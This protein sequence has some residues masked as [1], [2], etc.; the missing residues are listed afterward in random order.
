MKHFALPQQ[1]RSA[2]VIGINERNFS[3]V[4]RFNTRKSMRVANDKL[5]T[6]ELGEAMGIPCPA[7]LGVVRHCRD[8]K[9]A[10]DM[11]DPVRGA[12]IKPSQ[13]AGSN[14]I[15][16]L[17]S[18]TRN[19]FVKASG[20]FVSD[21]DV[22]WHVS[23]ILSGVFS[24]GGEPDV[25]MVE[26]RIEFDSCF[27]HV[28][29]KGVPDI[30]IIALRG[31][32]IAGMLRLPTKQSDGKAN[33]HKCGVGVGICLA[34]GR[35]TGAMHDGQRIAFHPDTGA[36]LMQLGVPHWQVMLTMAARC[37]EMSGLGY[38]GADIVLDRNQGPLLLELNARPGI[39]IQIANNEGLKSRI[40]ELVD[41][42]TSAWDANQRVEIAQ[43]MSRAA[44]PELAELAPVDAPPFVP[45]TLNLN[46]QAVA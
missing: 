46:W 34:N 30:R 17:T 32:P 12:V 21:D 19:G 35:A 9:R 6:K 37:Y 40:D 26:Q 4:S 45:P 13:G 41:R 7:L 20:A 10:L 3:L 38:L 23:N 1:L 8:T 28:S 39:S 29:Y 18:R 15:L 24:L 27:D 33:L 14:G 11:I 25:A 16:V 42:D 44:R 22:L 43:Q 31:V 36:P 2:G 5:T